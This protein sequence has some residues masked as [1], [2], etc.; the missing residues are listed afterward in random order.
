M[1]VSRIANVSFFQS[2]TWSQ[3]VSGGEG[4]G[5][6]WPQGRGLPGFRGGDYLAS[7]SDSLAMRC[8]TE[9][10]SPMKG[11]PGLRDRGSRVRLTPDNLKGCYLLV[12]D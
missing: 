7:G 2:G 11:M 12:F 1:L 8:D 10:L 3:G 4:R 5:I 6:T 9:D